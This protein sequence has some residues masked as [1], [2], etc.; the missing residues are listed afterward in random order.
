MANNGF[1]STDNQVDPPP[2]GSID[3]GLAE[4]ID[5]STNPL[6]TYMCEALPGASSATAV[7]RISRLTNA[8]G[9]IQ[10]A[11]GDAKFDNIADNRALLPY[12]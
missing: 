5:Q 7:W 3:V 12:S 4:I 1:P 11:N 2:W 9:V 6:Y 10:W 8:T